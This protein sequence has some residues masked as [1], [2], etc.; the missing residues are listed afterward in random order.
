MARN[1]IDNIGSAAEVSQWN[2]TWNDLNVL[3]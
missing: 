2:S 1:T 3:I